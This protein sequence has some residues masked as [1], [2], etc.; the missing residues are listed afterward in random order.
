MLE[1]NSPTISYPTVYRWWL[2]KR[3][4]K[5]RKVTSGL[6]IFTQNENRDYESYTH[7]LYFYPFRFESDISVGI[8]PSYTK[9]IAEPGVIDTIITNR[10]FIG[11]CIGCQNTTFFYNVLQ[12]NTKTLQ[13]HSLWFYK[14]KIYT[15]IYYKLKS[16]P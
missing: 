3:K 13:N 1:V 10:A 12:T 11:K 2:L 7:Q 4:I 8:P 14:L 15:A 16:V 6:R 9:K 5:C